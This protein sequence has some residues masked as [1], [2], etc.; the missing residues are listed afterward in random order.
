MDF[1]LSR[2]SYATIL[3]SYILVRTELDDR[4]ILQFLV[5]VSELHIRILVSNF[6]KSV[7][8][9]LF[10]RKFNTAQALILNINLTTLIARY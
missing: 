1:P 8:K 10:Q 4:L 9:Q 6:R 5:C 7:I 3:K 2:A